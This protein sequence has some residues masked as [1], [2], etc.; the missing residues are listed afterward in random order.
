MNDVVTDIAW[1]VTIRTN[2]VVGMTDEAKTKFISDLNKAI[3]T[4]CWSYGVHN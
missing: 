2:D 4:I 1:Q 3:Q